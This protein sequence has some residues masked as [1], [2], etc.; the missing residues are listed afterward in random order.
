MRLFWGVTRYALRA[1]LWRVGFRSDQRA[2]PY[3]WLQPVVALT[4]VG[5]F[6]TISEKAEKAEEF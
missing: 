2:A 3:H 1:S 4:S 6:T 5:A